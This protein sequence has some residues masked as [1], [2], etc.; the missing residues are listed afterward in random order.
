MNQFL[1]KHKKLISF[2][3]ACFCMYYL[4]FTHIIAY[5]SLIKSNS[6]SALIYLAAFT[7]LFY[8]VMGHA[9]RRQVLCALSAGFIFACC[10]CIG[11]E[12]V[13]TQM[14]N[15]TYVM[16]YLGILALTCVLTACITMV[17]YFFPKII[18]FIKYSRMTALTDRLFHHR[19]SFRIL[20]VL[21]LIL[22]IPAFL[23][24]FPGIYS[25]DAGPQVWQLFSDHRL[26]AHHPVIH[27]LILDGCFYIG[28]AV[29]GDYNNG[30]VLYSVIQA[31]FM[32]AVFAYAIDTMKKYKVPSPVQLVSLLFLAVNPISQVWVFTTTKDTMFGGFFLLL[33]LRM[34]DIVIHP[35]EFFSSR[36]KIILFIITAILTCLFRNQGIYVF[37]LC[38]PFM[39]I[40][41]KNYRKQFLIF[42]LIPVIIVKVLTGPVSS[43]LDIKEPNSREALSVPI[44]QIA[45][46]FYYNPGSIDEQT[47]ETIYK[48][49]PAK[50]LKGY[51]A[52]TSDPVKE[53]FNDKQFKKDPVSFF[54]A[55]A[56]IGIINPQIYIDS[57]L[58]GSYGY[59]Y[60]DQTPYWIHFILFDGAYMEHKNN[61]LDIERHSLLPGYESY[62][63]SVSIDLS[64]EKIPVIS[65]ILNQAF[66]FWMM[67]FVGSLLLYKKRYKEMIPLLLIL[68]FWGTNLLGPL[69]AI[70]YAYPI[71]VCVPTMAGLL[72][73]PKRD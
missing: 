57:F 50:Y 14:F 24:V 68:G 27:T 21:I 53:G 63:R 9:N 59:F 39:I 48:Y 30:L 64:H 16:I 41:L 55:W 34:I 67:I 1:T 11:S 71:I 46:V 60:P 18:H 65:F 49:I 42:S 45:R 47:K 31:L 73:Y 6:F 37:L 26:D 62:L 32:A 51:I 22:W 4:S 35:E 61:I 38:I 69:I 25:Y 7:A 12:F 72:F 33:F 23:A 5:N 19:H 8:W 3:L 40:G 15:Y 44:Q 66:P 29:T 2:L 70:R 52:A 56:Q 13:A 28:H 10:I 54:K 20:M 58:Y 17:I 43:A 36:K